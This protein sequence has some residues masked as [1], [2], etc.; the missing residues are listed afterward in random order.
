MYVCMG[1]DSIDDTLKHEIITE[2]NIFN[3]A[4]K[5]AVHMATIMYWMP[6]VNWF[7]CMMWL[8]C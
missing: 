8:A 5:I 1:K 6:Y 4:A 3:M 7:L 2:H